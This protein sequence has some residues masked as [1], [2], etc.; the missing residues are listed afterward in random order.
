MKKHI[1]KIVTLLIFTAVGISSCSVEYREHRRAR[2]DHP[3]EHH[4]EVIQRY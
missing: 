2:Y 1:L 4:V 3:E